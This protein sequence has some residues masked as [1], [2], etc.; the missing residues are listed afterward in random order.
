MGRGGVTG[1]E[2]QRVLKI[3]AHIFVGNSRLCACNVEKEWR[4]VFSHGTCYKD[5][6]A[7][8]V[9]ML[10]NRFYVRPLKA[11]F[12]CYSLL[13]GVAGWPNYRRLREYPEVWQNITNR[14]D[15]QVKGY[16]IL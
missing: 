4:Y 12:V 8:P 5:D 2:R 1:T 6:K 16:I 9:F 15:V 11:G 13:H 10:V 7:L 3:T 14:A